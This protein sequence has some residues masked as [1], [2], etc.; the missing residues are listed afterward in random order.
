MSA[1]APL[2]VLFGLAAATASLALAGRP[3][4]PRDW[5]VGRLERRAA[6]LGDPVRVPAAAWI[7]GSAALG[8][9]LGTAGGLGVLAL[10]TALA[11]AFVPRWRLSGRVAARE[12]LVRD[13]FGSAIAAL[14]EAVRSGLTFPRALEAV[15]RDAPGLAGERLR[16]AASQLAGGMPLA[17]VLR[18]LGDRLQ[19][20]PVTLLV[21]T[22]L[23]CQPSGAK[24][25]EA[26]TEVAEAVRGGQRLDRY[27]EVQTAS[28]LQQ[29]RTLALV[30]AG[31]L[32]LTGLLYPDGARELLGT[33]PGQ[34]VLLF[35]G[36]LVFAGVRMGLGVIRRAGRR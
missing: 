11:V 7:V 19:L 10:P 18:P 36:V 20:E 4:R 2:A 13:Q 5:Y 31:F 25:A 27:V 30:P 12:R 29:L 9:A 1:I 22:V 8:V 24:L 16:R 21:A 17:E 28:G 23:V 14:A 26:L 15:A 33:V 35:A 3:T 34:L 6:E 32:L